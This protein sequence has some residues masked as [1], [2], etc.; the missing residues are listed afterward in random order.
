MSSNKQYA[1]VDYFQTNL[2]CGNELARANANM[3]LMGGV[4]FGAIAIGI[5]SDL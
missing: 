4:L 3:I 1:C 2:V 5:F